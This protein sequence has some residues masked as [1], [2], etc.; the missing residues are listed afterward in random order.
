MMDTGSYQ[1]TSSSLS[2]CAIVSLKNRHEQQKKKALQQITPFDVQLRLIQFLFC[3]FY[4][5]LLFLL[6]LSF[7]PSPSLSSGSTDL[8]TRGNNHRRVFPF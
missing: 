5:Q 6:L 1:D 2:K 3:S 7:S 8:T 4:R